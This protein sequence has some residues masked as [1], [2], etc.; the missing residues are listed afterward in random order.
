MLS[1]LHPQLRRLCEP[2]YVHL[3][4]LSTIVLPTSN[5]Q[6][7]R[8]RPV[9]AAAYD[10]AR[11]ESCFRGTRAQL[12]SEIQSWM[13]NS[14]AQPIYVLYGVAGIGKSTVAKTVAEQ[15]ANDGTLG[16]SFFFSRD[17]DNRKTAKSFFTTLAYHLCRHDPAIAEQIN[18]T[19]EGDPEIVERD[20]VQ[21]FNHLIAKPLRSTIRGENTI[22]LVID[23]LDEC[24]ESDAEAILTLLAEEVP[25]ITRLRVFITARP[26]RHIRSIL[27]QN[28]NHSQFHL[29]DIDQSIVKADI[30]SY[31]GFRLSTEQVR[32]MFPDLLPPIWQPTNNEADTLVE[33]SGKLFIIAATVARFI[34][35]PKQVDP[36]GQLARLLSGI[37]AM[38]FSGSHPMTTMDKVYMGII[39]AAQPDPIGEWIDRFQACVGTIVLLYDPLPC[40]ALAELIGIDIND[41]VR[42]LSNLH[43]LFAPSGNGQTFRVH[44]KSF[45]DFICDRDRCKGGPQ[46]WIDRKAHHLRIAKCCFHVMD[47]L[48]EQNLCGLER[49]EWHKDRVQILHRIQHRVSPCLAYACTYWA[50]HLV[51]AVKGEAGFD[52]EVVELLE[53][54][55][56]RHL[57]TWLEALSIIGRLDTA[58]SSLDMVRTLGGRVIAPT[59][60]LLPCN[61]TAKGIA[62]QHLQLSKGSDTRI[63]Q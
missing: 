57:L 2:L 9:R 14:G 51:A 27:E 20:P 25:Q 56:S 52:S 24:E 61:S 13:R 19:L 8:L 3:S 30:R 35:D 1:R 46:F 40:G 37:S 29:H 45:P 6:F 41:V 49:D 34:L 10:C 28:R 36:A 38:D 31:L 7:D 33:I 62:S 26:E 42:T 22:L 18:M 53:C 11:R 5:Q 60:R 55:A 43:S 39:L 54:F 16:A 21:Q 17:E 59:C 47:R 32:K 15:A 63:A 23:A 4:I 44:H 48:L 12:L 50:S 58:Y